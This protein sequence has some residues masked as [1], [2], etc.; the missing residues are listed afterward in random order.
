V[1][2]GAC[3]CTRLVFHG[4]NNQIFTARSMDW[5]SDITSNLWVLPRGMARIWGYEGGLMQ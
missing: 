4:A 5:K 1:L 2:S 3:A